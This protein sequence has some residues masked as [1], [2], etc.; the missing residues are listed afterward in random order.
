MAIYVWKCKKCDHEQEVERKISESDW[1]PTE[2]EECG[3]KS[4]QMWEKIIQP[5]NFK[6]QGGGWFKDSYQKPGGNK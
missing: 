3:T 5:T 2:C 1:P 4:Y 6:L